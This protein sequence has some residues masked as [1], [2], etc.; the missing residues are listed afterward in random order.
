MHGVFDLHFFVLRDFFF[1]EVEKKD[2]IVVESE[3]E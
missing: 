1:G 2:G 3:F